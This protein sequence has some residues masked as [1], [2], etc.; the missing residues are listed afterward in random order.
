VESIMLRVVTAAKTV[1]INGDR[2]YVVGRG[3]EADIVVTGG[4]VSRRHVALE[5]GDRG[6]IARDL[7]ANGIW[8]DGHRASTV[9]LLPVD[10]AH[11]AHA[12]PTVIRLGAADGPRVSLLATWPPT[13][14]PAE[15]ESDDISHEQTMIAP[16]GRS[17]QTPSAAK[18]AARRRRRWFRTAPTLLWLV[19]AG[20]TVGALIALS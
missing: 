13:L 16:G 9:P 11:L 12:T 4:K 2:S 8:V 15:R 18:P 19:A 10:A 20:F 3:R 14:A 7:S 17:A 5:P 6:W 1:T